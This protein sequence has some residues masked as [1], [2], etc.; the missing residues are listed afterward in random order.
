MRHIHANGRTAPTRTR[1]PSARKRGFTL[2]ELLVVIAIIALLVSILMPSLRSARTLAAVSACGV[3]LRG[4][5]T[6]LHL[7]CAE[8]DDKLPYTQG[9]ANIETYAIMPRWDLDHDGAMRPTGYGVMYEEGFIDDH[10][11][12]YCPDA[13]A[14]QSASQ[15]AD[16]AAARMEHINNFHERWESRN[17]AWWWEGGEIWMRCDYVLGYWCDQGTYP[18]PLPFGWSEPKTLT[19]YATKRTL[20]AADAFDFLWGERPYHC[21]SHNDVQYMNVATTGGA[22]VTIQDLLDPD[23]I[24]AIQTAGGNDYSKA[25]NSRPFWNWWSYYAKGRLP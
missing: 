7:Y 5:V 11:S 22:V 14:Y 18:G 12:L 3:Q 9:V 15:V 2:I 13:R 10:R 1:H 8:W 25:E 16:P 21:R 6:S 23:N 24:S 20:I 17:E 4:L 19:N